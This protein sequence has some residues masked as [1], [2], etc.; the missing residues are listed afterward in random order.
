MATDA[1]LLAIFNAAVAED[2]DIGT[3]I[4]VIEAHAAEIL[5]ADDLANYDALPDGGGRQGAVADG[6]K[7]IAELFGDFTFTTVA[8][9]KAALTLHVTMEFNKQSFIQAL[10]GATD[11]ASMVGAIESTLGIVNNDRQ[12]LI[13]DWGTSDIDAVKD[14][15]AEL[16]ADEYTL[17]LKAISA[18]IAA[19]PAFIEDLAEDLLEAR[20]TGDGHFFGVTEIIGALDAAND[21]INYAPTVD[22]ETAFTTDEDMAV[23]GDIGA[24]D[25][26]GDSLSYTVKDGAGPTKGAVTFADGKFTYTPA[27]NA[28]GADTFTVVVD[29][30]NGGSV[31]QTFTITITPANDA[32]MVDAATAAFTT[33]EGTALVREIGASDVDGDDLTYM[34][35]TD[36]APTKGAVTF[37]DGKFTYTPAANANG[38]D[39]FTVVVSDGT[40]SVEKTFTITINPVN[41]PPVVDAPTATFTTDEDTAIVKDVGATDVETTVENLIYTVKTGAGPAKG[42]VT[43]AGGKFTYTPTANANGNDTFTVVISDGVASVE[44]TFTINITPANDTPIADAK[45]TFAMNEDSRLMADIGVTDIDGD[46]LTYALKEGAAPSKGAVTFEGGKFTYIPTANINGTDKFTVVASDGHGGTVEKTF[47]INIAAVND[48]PSDVRLS[49]ATVAENAANGTVVGALSALDLDGDAAF[50]Y[51]L[52]DNAGGRFAIQNGN[53]TVANGTLLDYEQ[54]N[55]HTISVR[56]ND[57]GGMSFVK[58]FKVSLTDVL[59][60]SVV[61]STQADVLVGGTGNDKL[62]GKAGKNTLTGGAGKDMFI[63]DAKLDKKNNITKVTDFTVKQDKIALDASIFKKIGKG[64]EAKPGKLKD[65]FFTIGKKATDDH[66]Q[67]IYDNKKG[68]LSYD[69]DGTGSKAAVQFATLA[70]KLKIS[71]KDFLIV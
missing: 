65:D 25:V 23:G 47:T 45:T 53:L 31:E 67:I 69:V 57:A 58:T 71:E 5:E 8:D 9:I 26:D 51:T 36:A 14:R 17:V 54:A 24:S 60:E 32:P 7:E 21:A 11:I 35:K 62:V 48:A 13:E 10:D 40:E 3:L 50:S 43:F 19:N 52:V 2:A 56:V 12:A 6:V 34:V 70:T 46:T 1:E 38:T 39:T 33:N 59:N 42:A 41:T 16:Q 28:N 44:K 68:T 30:G 49:N 4:G 37:A 29:D 64:T 18:R 66:A 27:A 63:F 20:A 15:V 55:G 22:G 61:G